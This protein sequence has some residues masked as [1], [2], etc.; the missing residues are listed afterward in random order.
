MDARSG[1]EKSMLVLK[2]LLILAGVGLFGSA[3]ALVVYDIY[4]S[5]Q[6]RRLLR[7][8]A[9]AGDATAGSTASANGGVDAANFLDD[10]DHPLR[11]IRWRLARQLVISGVVPVL[12]ALSIIVV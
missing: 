10:I 2:Y 7:R 9:P 3:A 12:L 5:S 11:P 1:E 8:N 4:I 6:L